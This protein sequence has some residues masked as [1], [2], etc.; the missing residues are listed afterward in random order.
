MSHL[1]EVENLVKEY[2]KSQSQALRGISLGVSH[3]SF[4]SFVGP[5][6]AGK[7]TTIGIICTLL[8]KTSGEVHVGGYSV[9]SEDGHVR[10]QIGVVF[11]H[12]LLDSDLTV[13]ENLRLRASLYGISDREAAR[14]IA[15]ISGED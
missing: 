7:S 11:Q 15:S 9:G 14:R 4:V 1:L 3:G 13:L 2:P 8:K 12:S 6:G 5:N 10:E